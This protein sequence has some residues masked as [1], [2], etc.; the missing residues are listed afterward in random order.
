MRESARRRGRCFAEDE[1]LDESPD[2]QYDRELSQEETLRKRHPSVS[3]Q[4]GAF[5]RTSLYV[6]GLGRNWREFI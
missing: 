1:E 2:Q 3:C 4:R 5:K 6:R